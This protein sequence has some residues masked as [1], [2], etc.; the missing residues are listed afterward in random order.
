MQY[1]SSSQKCLKEYWVDFHV[2]NWFLYL[3]DLNLIE[4]I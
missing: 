4:H 2:F 1:N 3:L